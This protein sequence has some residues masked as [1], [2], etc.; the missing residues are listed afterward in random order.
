MQ[1]LAAGGEGGGGKL[2]ELR[3]PL[4]QVGQQ[5]VLVDLNPSLLQGRHHCLLHLKVVKAGGGGWRRG[6]GHVDASTLDAQLLQSLHSGKNVDAVAI[7]D[8]VICT[9]KPGGS[10]APL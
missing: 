9:D 7:D 8:G 1:R 10:V 2:L 3:L 4:V 5:A 6:K